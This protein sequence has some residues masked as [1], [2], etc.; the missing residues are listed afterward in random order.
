GVAAAARATLT[1][2]VDAVTFTNGGGAGYTSVPTVAFSSGGGT[3]AAATASLT[4]TTP[5]GSKAIQELFEMDYGRMNATLGVELPFTNSLNQTTIPYG[6]ID[7][8]TEFL[9]PGGVQI[10]KIT[11]NGVDTHAVHFHLFNVQVINRVGWDGAIRPPEPNELGWKDTVR[12]SPLEDTIVALKPV[13][14]TIPFNIPD[15]VRPLDPTMPL[16]STAGFF[17]VDPLGNPVTVVNQII[18]FG[19]EYVWHC[20]M[21]DHEEMDMMRPVIFQAPAL[22]AAPYDVI[23]APGNGGAVVT[24]TPAPLHNLSSPNTGYTV[25]SSPGGRTATGSA[26]PLTVTGLTN[27]TSYTF[28]VKAANAL[29]TGPASIASNSITPAAGLTAP[30]VP[31]GVTAVAGSSQATVSF[32]PPV[33]NGGNP[34]TGYTVTSNPGGITASG[35]MGPIAVTGLTNGTAYTFTVTATNAIGTSASS[36]ASNIV[37]PA[38]VTVPGA[39]MMMSAIA[40]NAQ[41]IVDFMAPG[42]DGGSPITMYMVTSTPGNR[43]AS[44][45]MGPLTV[46]GLTNGTTYTFTVTAMNAIGTGPASAMSQSVTPLAALAAPGTPTAVSA[47]AGNTTATVSFTAPASTGGYPITQYTVTSSPGGITATGTAS[48]ITVTGLTNGTAYTFT[49]TA[50]NVLGTGTASLPSAGVTPVSVPGTP[51]GVT[52]V[53]GNGGATVTFTAPAANGSPITSYTVTSNPGNITATGTTTSIVVPGLSNGTVY[54]FTVKA[55]NANGTGPVSAPSNMVTPVGGPGIPTGVTAVAGNALATV[56]F[57]A[58][59]SGGGA[60][61]G[62]TVTPYVGAVAGTPTS[63]T[64]SPITVTGLINGTTYTFTVTATSAGGTSAASAPSNSVTPATVPDAPTAVSAVQGNTQATV[65]FTA[66]ASNGGSPILTYLVTSSPGGI[67]ASGAASPITVT[68]LTNGTAYTFTV[69]AIN[70]IGTGVAST[71]SASVTPGVTVPGAPTGVVAVAGN[72]QATVGF[73]A[74]ASDGGNPITLYTVTSAPGGITATGTASPI[75]ITGLTNG[76][77]YTFTVTATNAIGAGAASVPSTAVTPNVV[78]GAPTAVSAAAGNAQATVSFTAPAPNGGTAV[79]G[80]TVTSS[81]GGITAAGAA[82]LITITGLTLGTTYTFTVMAT[83]SA[84]TSAASTPSSSITLPSAV[85]GA[86]TGIVAVPGNGQASVM[87]TAPASNGGGVIT[88]YTVTSSPGNISAVGGAS[89]ITVPG[90]SNG[91]A[92]T[93][94]VTAANVI[95]AGPASSASTGITPAGL[96]ASA[97]I[98]RVVTANLDADPRKDLIVDFGPASGLWVCYNDSTWQQLSTLSTSAISVGNSNGGTGTDDLIVDFG[99][100]NGLWIYSNA[101]WAQISPSTTV[102]IATGHL[103]GGNPYQLIASFASSGTWIYD[104]GTWTQLSAVAAQSIAAGDVDADGND[105]IIGNFTQSGL[106]IYA[107]GVWTNIV[108]VAAQSAITGDINGDGKAEIIANFTQNG[109]WVYGNNAWT[110]LVTVPALSI[111]TANVDGTG[112]VDL[113]AMFDATNGIWIYYNNSIWVQLSP[114]TAVSVTAGNMDGNPAGMAD[115]AVDFGTPNGVWVYYDNAT[116]I[117]LV[118]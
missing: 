60:I 65:S 74:P 108:S 56:S 48:P 100:T 95:G 91:T 103:N 11:H 76:T 69:A 72:T 58:P 96:P 82:S 54:S 105:E 18:N 53:A 31:T 14:P 98:D 67:T 83:N 110:H 59:A 112:P 5:M 34:I 116:W 68:G 36:G 29:G 42:S 15:S 25:T 7:P 13:T 102:S 88:S 3:G 50:T 73:I 86:P 89:P 37:I 20:H 93:F 8:P 64:A 94:T 77:A 81:P 99:A 32:T 28:T 52:A 9:Q 10:W 97:G 51:T 12:M 118:Q 111:M 30:G 57:T 24:F 40:G 90:L 16:G 115:V 70:A 49:V 63:G 38:A 6:Y 66:P 71:P 92:Y 27:G 114:F 109:I 84:G 107:T 4:R 43:T 79:T 35:M 80:Y 75:V 23:A 106:W 101:V 19:W 21:L 55:T 78:P 117:Q 44:G 87:F 39:P 104:T 2:V 17:G 85:P 1:G 41:A 45:M 46:T 61:T 47:V 62:Y 113:I 26:S 33:S 22:P